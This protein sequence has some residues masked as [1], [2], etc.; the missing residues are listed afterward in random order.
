[1]KYCINGVKV[2]VN[3]KHK[4]K[5]FQK[6]LRGLFFVCL[7]IRLTTVESK[8]QQQYLNSFIGPAIMT[9]VYYCPTIQ[10]KPWM[11]IIFGGRLT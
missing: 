11:A 7:F 8:L 9:H 6:L 2:D 5:N 10:A 3:K 1:M 4:Q